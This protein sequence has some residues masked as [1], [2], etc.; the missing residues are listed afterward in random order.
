[1]SQQYHLSR[2][3][4]DWRFCF[5]RV[6]VW[7]IVC[8][9]CTHMREAMRRDCGRS[10]HCE[11][12]LLRRPSRPINFRGRQVRSLHYYGRV[13]MPISTPDARMRSGYGGP[14]HYRNHFPERGSASFRVPPPRK[15]PGVY[16][17]PQS[18]PVAGHHGGKRLDGGEPSRLTM[19]SR[20]G[21]LRDFLGDI[22]LCEGIS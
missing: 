14:R 21:N 10:R 1:M 12:R 18:G 19:T 13:F 20:F 15:G 9:G 22:R 3:P 4:G 16:G 8:N 17:R 6:R 2:P 5:V 7:R 11:G